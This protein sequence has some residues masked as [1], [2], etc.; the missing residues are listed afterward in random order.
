MAEIEVHS[1]VYDVA[2]AALTEAASKLAAA[3]GTVSSAVPAMA[4]GP[5][6][7]FIPPVLNSV[8]SVVEG[9]AGFVGTVSQRT[10]DGVQTAV[11]GFRTVDENGRADLDRIAA[12]S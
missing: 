12:E 4:F 9:A 3:R 11:E 5:I 6:G 1:D 10:A 2:R 7:A 8:G